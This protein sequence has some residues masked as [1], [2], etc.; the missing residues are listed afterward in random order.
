MFV[1]SYFSWCSDQILGKLALSLRVQTSRQQE[2]HGSRSKSCWHIGSVVR[3]QEEGWMPCTPLAL[4][5]CVQ[6][7]TLGHGIVPKLRVGVPPS[8]RERFPSENAFSLTQMFVSWE[9][10]N[11][12]KFDCC[13]PCLFISYFLQK[14]LT[15]LLYQSIS[16]LSKKGLVLISGEHASEFVCNQLWVPVINSWH[17]CFV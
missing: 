12:I 5:L 17:N 14:L 10:L 4:F 9:I 11:S 8:T 15:D 13:D 7:G 1:S 2:H 6:P 3:K 16:S